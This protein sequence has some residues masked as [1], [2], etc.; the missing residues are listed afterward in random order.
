MKRIPALGED[1]GGD[2][3]H[4]RGFV[5]QNKRLGCYL[6]ECDGGI[7]GLR[8]RMMGRH[9]QVKRLAIEFFD[10]QQFRMLS[11]IEYQAKLHLSLFHRRNQLIGM[12]HTYLQPDMR[13]ALTKRSKERRQENG[14]QRFDAADQDGAALSG[15]QLAEELLPLLQLFHRTADIE[16]ELAARRSQ[17]DTLLLAR[18]ERYL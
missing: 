13:V 17:R 9:E 15:L 10:D 2:L 1:S 6:R 5:Q 8:K 16:R 7:F 12:I 3:P 18:K 11:G 4:A 14:C